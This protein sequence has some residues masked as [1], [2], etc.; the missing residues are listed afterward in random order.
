MRTGNALAHSFNPTAAATREA[1]WMLTPGSPSSTRRCVEG[2]TPAS[3]AAEFRV[4]ARLVRA[5]VT[6]RPIDSP[7][8]RAVRRHIASDDG[9]M[10]NRVTVGLI[11]ALSMG[12]R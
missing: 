4:R 12:Y 10:P 8:S 3:R 5:R 6:S 2:E 11:G 9:L 7:M 1:V